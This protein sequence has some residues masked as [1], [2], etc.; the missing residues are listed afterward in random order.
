MVS[1][2]MEAFKAFADSVEGVYPYCELRSTRSNFHCKWLLLK[3]KKTALANRPGG[4]FVLQSSCIS[5]EI[6]RELIISK[7]ALPVAPVFETIIESAET[8]LTTVKKGWDQEALDYV[9]HHSD[10][11][12]EEFTVYQELVK[13]VIQPRIAEY[14]LEH[15]VQESIMQEW[16]VY[17]GFMYTMVTSD[18]KRLVSGS[19]NYTDTR[20]GAWWNSTATNSSTPQLTESHPVPNV[21][22]PSPVS[23]QSSIAGEPTFYY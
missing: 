20:I 23:S 15:A 14:F 16:M 2:N 9:Y 7:E 19:I 11:Q 6:Q 5:K 10:T 21:V 13:M 8:W 18:F 17:F 12:K 4:Y 22:P 1:I 3:A